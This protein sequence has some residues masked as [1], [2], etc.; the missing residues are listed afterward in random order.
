MQFTSQRS[1]CGRCSLL[2][3]LGTHWQGRWHRE[4]QDGTLSSRHPASAT[5]PAAP[6]GACPVQ[7]QLGREDSHLRSMRQLVCSSHCLPCRTGQRE[8]AGL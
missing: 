3:A 4:L 8:A 2:S 7:C 6:F 1:G 5:L